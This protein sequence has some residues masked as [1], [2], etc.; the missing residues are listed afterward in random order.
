LSVFR[1]HGVWE[2]AWIGVP[3]HTQDL[4]VMSGVT[5]GKTLRRG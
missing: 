2:E 3:N 4:R 1:A 5:S